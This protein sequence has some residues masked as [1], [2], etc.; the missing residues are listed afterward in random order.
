[1]HISK[2]L[3]IPIHNRFHSDQSIV[4]TNTHKISVFN[5]RFHLP[6]H[7]RVFFTYRETKLMLKEFPHLRSDK[8]GKTKSSNILIK[9]S[10]VQRKLSLSLHFYATS[11]NDPRHC[12]KQL[13]N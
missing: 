13:Q 6:S 9:Q 10:H 3:C 8:G 11:T 1:M 7:K 12:H 5:F 2:E 4:P